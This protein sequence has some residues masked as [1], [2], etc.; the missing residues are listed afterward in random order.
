MCCFR[1]LKA[2]TTPKSNDNCN[3]SD[4]GKVVKTAKVFVDDLSDTSQAAL[5][6]LLSGLHKLSDEG[7]D[8]VG[9]GVES[10]VS[11]VED[12]DLCVRDVLAIAFGFT[13]V[14]G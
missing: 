4:S 10:E 9:F 6:G 11:G 12:V 14:E 2:A 13:E 8:F 3:D 7:R 5:I 1:G